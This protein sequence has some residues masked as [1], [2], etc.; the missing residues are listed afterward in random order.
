MNL[1][2]THDP[3][4]RSWLPSANVTST[5]FPIQNL[6]HGVFRRRG[7]DEASRGGVAIGDQILDVTAALGAGAFCGDMQMAASA[8]GASELNA[9]MA[10]GKP[11]WSAFRAELSRVLGKDAPEADKLAACLVPQAQAEYALPARVGDYSDFFTSYDHMVNMGRLFLPDNPA[12]PQFKWLPIAYHGRASTIEISGTDFQ[13]PWGQGR[14]PGAANPCFAPT[15]RLD[16]E[17]EIGAWVGTG[18]PRGKPIGIDDAEDHLFGL[19]L[20]NDWSSRD[21]Q[22][23]ESIPLGP[24][25]AKSF[26][27]SV[28]PWIVTMEALEPFRCSL[29]RAPGDPNVLPYLLPKNGL[30]K[31]GIDL[32]V[33]VQ[34]AT[35]TSDTP[36]QVSLSSMRHAYWGFGQML[37]HHTENGCRM[38]PGDLIGSGTQSGPTD[39][40]KGCLMERTFGGREPMVLPNGEERTMLEDGDTVILRAWAEKPGAVRIGLGECRG[41]VL[42]ARNA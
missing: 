8:A 29:P 11:V 38:N 31:S 27:T 17:M 13:R 23:W 35:L 10:M 20:L 22:G 1:N 42:P 40:E 4:L 26:F 25:L 14:S 16:Y 36:M 33:E 2:A 3:S 30:A 15:Q 24:F 7:R 39:T 32:T 6:P 37:A 18:N 19:C 28:S 34:M 5:D 21:V 9:F 12:L 41:T